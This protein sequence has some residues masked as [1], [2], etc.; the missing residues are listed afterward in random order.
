MSFGGSGGSM[1]VSSLRPGDPV[2]GVFACVRKDR[3]MT[4]SGSPYLAL[5]LRDQTGSVAARV[6]R[7]AD[8]L[9]GGFER[10]DLVSVAGMV[11]RFR[12]ELVLELSSVARAGDGE[13]DPAA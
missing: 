8:A 3:L 2:E 10:G 12:D 7:D 11:E 5:E 6:F 1:T 13:V 9:A 4:R